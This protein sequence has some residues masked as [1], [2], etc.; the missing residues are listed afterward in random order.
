MQPTLKGA[1]ERGSAGLLGAQEGSTVALWA[2]C[3]SWV[4]ISPPHRGFAT[5]LNGGWAP[6]EHAEAYY[7]EFRV[8]LQDAT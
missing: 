6:G 8:W 2:S 5:S 4:S 3:W 1:G 7:R